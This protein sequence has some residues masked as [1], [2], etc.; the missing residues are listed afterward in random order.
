MATLFAILLTM[1]P[2]CSIKFGQFGQTITVITPFADTTTYSPGVVPGEF[3]TSK[4]E[5]C[6]IFDNQ[7]NCMQ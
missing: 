2:D 3:V 5:T 4:G 7:L 6:E 1:F